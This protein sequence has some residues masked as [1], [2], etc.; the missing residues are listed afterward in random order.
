MNFELTKEQKM[1][2]KSIREFAKNEIAPIV[3]E[4]D[5]KGAIPNEII[6]GMGK[7]NLLCMSVDEKYGGINADPIT[8][9][10]VAE[11]LARADIS[12]AIPTLFLVEASWG[13]ILQRYGTEE[14]KE[15][16]LPDA[17]N[18]DAFLGI[19]ATEPDAGSD[20]LGMSTKAKKVDDGYILNGG[21]MFISGVK[22]VMH[23][24]PKGGGYVTLAKT[25]PKKGAKGMSLFFLPLS[26]SEGVETTSFDD[27]GR[28]GISAGGFML[29]DVKIP[30]EYLIGEENRGFYITMEGFDYA[31]AIIAVVCCAAATSAMEKA[32]EYIKERKAFGWP[33]GKFGTVQMRLA[34]HW[35]KIQSVR[36]MA[37]DALWTLKQEIEG[38]RKLRFESTLKCAQAKLLAPQ[39]SFE[40]IN[41]SIQFFGAFGYTTGCDLALALKGVR[42]YYWAEGTREIM[43]MIVGRELLGKEFVAYR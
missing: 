8:V 16:I 33:I 7:I 41:D 3:S 11:E 40:A 6:K 31:R 17:A 19:A 27:W 21:K 23:Q 5:Q 10:L 15:A 24:L 42:S 2:R 29:S 39:Y 25:D 28:R 35:A 12:C 14:A 18:G 1:I 38:N 30:H 32:I 26:S 4:I 9:A 34:E 36:L 37:Y 13:S 20:L 43:G 22:E